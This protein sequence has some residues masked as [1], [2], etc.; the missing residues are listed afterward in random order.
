MW[1][2]TLCKPHKNRS[3][4][5]SMRYSLFVTVVLAVPDYD[6]VGISRQRTKRAPSSAEKNYRLSAFEKDFDLVLQPNDDVINE[7]GVVV[8]R[9]TADGLMTRETHVP[10]GRFYVGH[11][12]SDPASHVAVR[13][14]VGQLVRC[15]TT[16]LMLFFLNERNTQCTCFNP[17]TL[18]YGR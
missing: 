2:R 11:V 16:L 1:P 17:L 4:A 18:G 12:A 13:E 6:V 5:V 9:R 8:E 3:H 15:F 7:E 14:N 10:Q